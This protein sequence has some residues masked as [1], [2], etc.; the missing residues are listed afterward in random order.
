LLL[1]KSLKDH[2]QSRVNRTRGSIDN[3]GT[4]GLM[5]MGAWRHRR[6]RRNPKIIIIIIAIIIIIRNCCAL[7]L[8]LMESCILCLRVDHWIRYRH[9]VLMGWTV[10]AKVEARGLKGALELW[11]LDQL[12]EDVAEIMC[13]G[14]LS[15]GTKTIQYCVLDLTYKEVNNIILGVRDQGTK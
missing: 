15:P 4:P 12:H 6:R 13:I 10:G 3:T 11:W 9:W 2:S 7:S 14:Q 5:I 1:C 8:E